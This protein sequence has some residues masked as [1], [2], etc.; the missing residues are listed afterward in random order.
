M[1]WLRSLCGSHSRRFADCT[2]WHALPAFGTSRQHAPNNSSFK[3][4]KLHS[5]NLLHVPKYSINGH[6]IPLLV[7]FTARAALPML[8]LRE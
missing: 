7:L 8:V 1:V 3:Q 2:Y 5:F 6:V 4:P